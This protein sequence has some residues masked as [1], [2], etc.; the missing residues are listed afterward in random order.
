MTLENKPE[1]EH[2]PKDG[3]EEGV[4]VTEVLDMTG[5]DLATTAVAIIW[6]SAIFSAIVDNIPFVATMIP[7]IEKLRAMSPFWKDGK[8]V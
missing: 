6:V 1:N 4:D 3:D 8:M 5:G 7:T 2:Y